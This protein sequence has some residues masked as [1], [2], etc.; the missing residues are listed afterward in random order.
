MGG[1]PGMTGAPLTIAIDE[2]TAILVVQ[3]GTGAEREYTLAEPAVTIGRAEDNQVVISDNF[4]SR[5]HA[6]IVR[7]GGRYTWSDVEGV[8]VSTK[9]NGTPVTGPRLL[10]DED[11]IEL[12][13]TT[14]LFR[15]SPLRQS[16]PERPGMASVSPI[17]APG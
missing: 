5:R 13:Q 14:L 9:I 1:A 4:V 12:G 8:R 11:K 6:R 17:P 3:P 16:T 7:E 2:N 15:E 10:R